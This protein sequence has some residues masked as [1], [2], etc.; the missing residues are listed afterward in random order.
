MKNNGP[1]PSGPGILE[2]KIFK[3]IFMKNNENFVKI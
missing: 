3:E 1:G 2:E